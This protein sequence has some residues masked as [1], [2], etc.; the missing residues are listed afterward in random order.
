MKA[1]LPFTFCIVCGLLIFCTLFVG[2]RTDR[3]AKKAS[4]L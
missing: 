4:K 2:M 1:F 3:R